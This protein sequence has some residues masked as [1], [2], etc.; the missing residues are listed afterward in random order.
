M[1]RVFYKFPAI[2][3]DNIRLPVVAG[4]LVAVSDAG[5]TMVTIQNKGT[6]QPVVSADFTQV[7]DVNSHGFD[8][9]QDCVDYLNTQF[10][11][12]PESVYQETL[13]IKMQ[14]V[15]PPLSNA[16]ASAPGA[17]AN[18]IAGAVT[19][20]SGNGVVLFT[21]GSQTVTF[22]ASAAGFN[23]NPGETVIAQYSSTP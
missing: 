15:I 14:N 9:V 16:W 7:G 19:F 23:L 11:L 8:N 2:S 20:T 18:I 17:F 13:T 3:I 4:S 5:S 22:N 21:D 10:A 1:I 6:S 12:R